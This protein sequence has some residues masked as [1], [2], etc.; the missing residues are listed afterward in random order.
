MQIQE[1][2]K[3]IQEI[4]LHLIIFYVIFKLLVLDIN[5]RDTHFQVHTL[6]NHII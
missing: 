3:S 6:T 2:Y 4:L 5:V 1:L